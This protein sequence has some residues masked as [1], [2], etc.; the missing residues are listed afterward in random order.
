MRPLAA[1][2]ISSLKPYVPGKPVEE[3]ERELGITG[4]VKLASNE[5]PLGP[6]TKAV[7]AISG[8]LGGLNRYP[9]GAGYYLK[10]AL[11]EKLGVTPDC[12]I[13]GNG[14]NELLE[15]AVRTFMQPGDGSV[16]AVN[17]FVVYSLV[18]KSAGCTGVAVP[19]ADGRHDLM[20]MAGAVTDDT[21]IVFVANP[22]NPTGTMNTAAELDAFMQALPRD[23]IAVLD[24]AY[25]EYAAGPDYPDSLGYVRNGRRVVAL[26]TF[27]KAYGLAGLR[28]GYGVAPPEL[29]DLMNRVRQPFNTGSLSQ[30]AALAALG[31]DEHVRRTVELNEEGKRYLYGELDRLG[32]R[33]YP[34]HANFIYMETGRDARGL[35]ELMLKDG[36]I[37]RPV[38]P[39]QIRVTI[40]L[41]GENRRFVEAFEK[42]LK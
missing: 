27:S 19:L 28:I 10:A 29:V 26:R 34:T 35:Y 25:Y 12:I 2:H 32:V 39:E 36:V 18:T 41:P 30:A 23:V 4:S 8:M 21:R 7:A 11:S 6:S 14:S 42:V 40:G 1:E 15:L 37:V 16:M 13:L 38:G 20:S 9:D 33:Y 17:S 24:E 22:N 31:D 5:N 3:L